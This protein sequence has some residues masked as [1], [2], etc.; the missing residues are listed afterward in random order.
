MINK[1]I[2]NLTQNCQRALTRIFRICDKDADNLL[3]DNEL[4]YL[5]L[6]VFKGE[7]TQGDIKGIKDVI[8]DEVNFF[9]FLN[10]LKDGKWWE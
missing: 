6:E 7:L 10:T 5:Q 3:K 9:F 2:K 1:L 4:I 8:K